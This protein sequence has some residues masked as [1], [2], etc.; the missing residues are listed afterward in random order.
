M[1]DEQYVTFEFGYISDN[2]C[3][4]DDFCNEVGLNPW[5]LN[6]GRAGSSDEYRMTVTVAKKYG[7]IA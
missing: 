4:W 3:C 6:E 1:S 2:V 7:L 5:L